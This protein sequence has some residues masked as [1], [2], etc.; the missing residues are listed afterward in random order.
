MKPG[1]EYGEAPAVKPVTWYVDYLSLRKTWSDVDM[2]KQWSI[3]SALLS[4]RKAVFRSSC[5]YFW[6]YEGAQWCSMT[7]TWQAKK[8]KELVRTRRVR[9]TKFFLGQSFSMQGEVFW[10]PSVG[11]KHSRLARKRCLALFKLLIPVGTGYSDSPNSRRWRKGVSINPLFSPLQ[12]FC[13][14]SSIISV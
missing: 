14:P 1:T 8:E 9:Y 7:D 6:S 10:A 13:S 2:V 12:C 11:L 3:C 4:S 5:G